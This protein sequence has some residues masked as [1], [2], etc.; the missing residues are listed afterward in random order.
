MD[1][2]LSWKLIQEYFQGEWVELADTEWKW[3]SAHPS[4]ARI[5]RHAAS[6][7]QLIKQI[8]REGSVPGSTILFVSPV[9]SALPVSVSSATC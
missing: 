9:Q 4:M 7:Q 6:R 5:V 1:E 8:Q 2:K 3:R